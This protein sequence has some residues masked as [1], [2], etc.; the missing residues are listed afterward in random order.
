MSSATV[1][2]IKAS[3]GSFGNVVGILVSRLDD[4]IAVDVTGMI[5]Q[6]VNYALKSSFVLAALE[7]AQE[8]RR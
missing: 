8:K 7:S 6:N 1:D 2:G 4:E 5:P 3:C